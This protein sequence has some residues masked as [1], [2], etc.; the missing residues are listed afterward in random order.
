MRVYILTSV[1]CF[2]K[3]HINQGHVGALSASW[4]QF[5]FQPERRDR[6]Q[7]IFIITLGCTTMSS[8]SINMHLPMVLY[9]TLN[10]FSTPN[11]VFA[12]SASHGKD[13]NE[14]FIVSPTWFCLKILFEPSCTIILITIWARRN[15]TTQ[16][17]V[18]WLRS[19]LAFVLGVKLKLNIKNQAC[20]GLAKLQ[21]NSRFWPKWKKNTCPS[22][23]TRT[24]TCRFLTC[25]LC[26]LFFKQFSVTHLL[27]WILVV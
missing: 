24:F 5:P 9:I 23:I 10:F 2:H 25:Q 8:V 27:S 18:Y 19:M 22:T 1:F 14:S 16:T 6:S 12:C 17:V 4:W 11:M 3:H 7:Y 26:M 15:K 13:W 20:E 21:K